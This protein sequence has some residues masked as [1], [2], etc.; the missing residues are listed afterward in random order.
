VLSVDRVLDRPPAAVAA[1]ATSA[2]LRVERLQHLGVDS[3]GREVP[4][5]GAH[6]LVQSLDVVLPGRRLQVGDLQPSIEELVQRGIRLWLAVLI[7][8][9]QEP[10]EGALGVG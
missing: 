8:L 6:V 2:Q 7:D 9:G 4:E 3:A 5:R 1:V 10:G